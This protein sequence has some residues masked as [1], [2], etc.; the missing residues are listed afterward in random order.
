MLKFLTVAPLYFIAFTAIIAGVDLAPSTGWPMNDREVVGCAM[1]AFGMI[2]KGIIY[3][4]PEARS[5]SYLLV[6]GIS[7]LIGRRF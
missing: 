3:L 7:P 4:T 1:L 5:G 6:I 2:I